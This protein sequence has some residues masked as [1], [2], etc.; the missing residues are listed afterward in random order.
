MIYTTNY[1]SPVGKILLASKNNKL[2]GLWIEGQTDYLEKLN[3]AIEIKENEE[4]LIKAKDWLDRY[5]RKEQPKI[6]EIEI[7]PIGGEFRQKVWKLLCKIPYGKITSYGEIAKK[8]AKIM[9]KEKMS[10][11]AVRRSCWT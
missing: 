7:A 10:A 5:F 8:L 2:I 11:Q 9:K 4:I 1:Q 3:D 6:D